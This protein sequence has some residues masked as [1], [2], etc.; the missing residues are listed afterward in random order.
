MNPF[1]AL[2]AG[3]PIV[4]MV[5]TNLINFLLISVGKRIPSK[6]RAKIEIGAGVLQGAFA[7]LLTRNLLLGLGN[8]DHPVVDAV[9]LL[10]TALT[11]GVGFWVFRVQQRAAYG[12]L[13]IAFAGTV[14]WII[15][16]HPHESALVN[17]TAIGTVVY[18][19]VRGL[20]NIEQGLPGGLYARLPMRWPAPRTAPLPDQANRSEP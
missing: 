5:L 17:A 6:W 3:E 9:F 18:V 16:L 8:G 19:V 14:A 2:L 20:D 12:A 10:I 4:L 11:L 1:S 13:E 15:G 7:A